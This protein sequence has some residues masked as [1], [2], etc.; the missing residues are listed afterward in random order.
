[1]GAAGTTTYHRDFPNAP[2]PA[3]WYPQALANSIAQVDL[4]PTQADIVAH[5]S[6]NLDGPS[7][8]GATSWYYGLDGNAPPGTVD[9]VTT[10]LH[11]LTHG[12]GCTSPMNLVTGAKFMGFNDTYMTNLE[13]HGAVVPLFMN[14]TNVQREQ[15]IK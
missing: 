14:M 15:A 9:L 8:L 6:S 5:F 13:S 12:L 2:V 7:C 11:E 4:A 3:T 1:L 10:V